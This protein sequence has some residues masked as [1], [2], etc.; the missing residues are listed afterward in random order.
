MDNNKGLIVV[1]GCSGRIGKRV[2]KRFSDQGFQVVG[3]DVVPPKGDCGNV[4]FVRIDLSSDESVHQ[5]FNHIREK[6][7]NRITSI[8][9][10]AA[11]YSFSKGK[12][13]LYESITVQ[14]T[15]RMLRECQQ[16]K[17]EQ[18]LF[19]STQLIYAPCELGQ[20]INEESPVEP[21][22]EYPKSKVR[23]EALMRSEHGQVPIM[24]MQIA[25]C[26]D[27]ECHS[28]PI[29]NEIQR[30]FE[31]Q[32]TSHVF[33]GNV[34]HGAPFLHLDDLTD[35]IQLS[36]EKRAEL[37]SETTLIIGES[38]TMSYDNMQREISKCLEGKDFTTFRVPKWFAKAGAWVENHTP[39]MEANFIE[40]WMID[41]AD[42]HYE[43]DISKAQKMLGW[44]PKH[45]VRNCLP[46]MI[47]SLQ[48]DPLGWYEMN[49]LKAPSWMKPEPANV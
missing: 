13:E 6:Y 25:G 19:S 22:W 26:Y 32:L 30:I 24:I 18:F 27:D 21:K 17:T 29:S 14:G 1:T 31:H 46:K 41:I 5:G 8:I 38:S 45:S 20:K 33:P 16:F 15:G 2:C 4:D 40:P 44:S 11:Y 42:D 23:T 28:I 48:K 43:L 37:P 9:H 3:F 7:G 36:V 12:R 39:F 34:Q 47:D 10:L 49:G 35:A